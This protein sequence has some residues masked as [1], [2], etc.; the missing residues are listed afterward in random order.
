[1]RLRTGVL[2]ATTFPQ[3]FEVERASLPFL[4]VSQDTLVDGKHGDRV[5]DH[6]QQVRRQSR[7]EDAPPFLVHDEFERLREAAVLGHARGGQRLSQPGPDHLVRVGDDGRDEL[8]RTG[9]EADLPF[10]PLDG[11]PVR[12]RSRPALELLVQRPLNRPLRDAEQ[13]RAQTAIETP[14][15]LIPEDVDRR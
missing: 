9:G 15:A 3:R 8:G 7:V 14:D 6:A 12:S 5:R 11:V 1:M 2:V 13:T 10:R 4:D